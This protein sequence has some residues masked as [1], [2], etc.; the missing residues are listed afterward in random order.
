MLLPVVP[1]LGR[2][3]MLPMTSKLTEDRTQLSL[4]WDWGLGE[5]VMGS[6]ERLCKQKVKVTH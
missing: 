4:L 6:R 1:V 2:I 3:L 5:R